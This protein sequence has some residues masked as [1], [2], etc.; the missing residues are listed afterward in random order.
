MIQL[1]ITYIHSDFQI[2]FLYIT[3]VGELKILHHPQRGTY[4]FLMRREQI[5]KLVLNHVIAADFQI[6]PMNT[7]GKAYLWG[8]MNYSE[9]GSNVEKLAA[10]FKNEDLAIKFKFEVDKCIDTLKGRENLEPEED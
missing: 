7:S 4:R 6:N 8:A 5:H 1:F 9:E 10:R 3:G 2:L